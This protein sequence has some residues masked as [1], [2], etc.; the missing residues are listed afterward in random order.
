[1]KKNRIKTIAGH[2]LVTNIHAKNARLDMLCLKY[3]GR[4]ESKPCELFDV[5]GITVFPLY[6]NDGG[7]ASAQASTSFTAYR[8][9]PA[10]RVQGLHGHFEQADRLL[11]TNLIYGKP[12]D[13]SEGF[14]IRFNR[15]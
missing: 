12:L 7:V 4:V 13:S 2:K 9:L 11:I 6:G 5:D 8:S 10:A 14:F 3:W 15:A 1:M